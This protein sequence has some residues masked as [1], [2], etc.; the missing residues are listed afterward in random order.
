VWDR[1]HAVETAG[2]QILHSEEREINEECFRQ[3]ID[4]RSVV[5]FNHSGIAGDSGAI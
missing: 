3:D 1:V 2:E 4:T 5:A